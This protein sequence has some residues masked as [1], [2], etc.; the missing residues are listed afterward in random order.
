ML[1]YILILHAQKSL[2]TL[3][4]VIRLNCS[5]SLI[6]PLCFSLCVLIANNITTVTRDHRPSANG[7]ICSG[8]LGAG[9]ELSIS[10]QN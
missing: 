10:L 6:H 5:T 3:I 2:C 9:A 8:T 4:Y 7:H 1:D